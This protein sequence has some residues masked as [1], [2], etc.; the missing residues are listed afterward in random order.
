VYQSNVRY[1]RLLP[2]LVSIVSIECVGV[3]Q[4]TFFPSNSILDSLQS[5]TA[6]TVPSNGDLNPYG[7]AFVP[8]EFPSGGTIGPGDVLVANFNNS[9]D[10]QGT[11]TTIVAISP[12]GQQS[13]LAMST[14]IGLDTALGVLSG[15][16]VIVG[17]LPVN[18][19]KIGQGSLQIFDR[20]GNLTATLTDPNL[21]DTLGT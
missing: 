20:H 7:V 21:L 3:A 10:T 18:G 6:S 16:F 17:N 11:G 4:R 1:H 5:I 2:I 19:G 9:D 8:R 15:G 13:V 14:P 12:T